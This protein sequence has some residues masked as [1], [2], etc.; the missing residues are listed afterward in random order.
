[1]LNIINGFYETDDLSDM[2]LLSNAFYQ[3]N[4]AGSWT[5]KVVDGVY[6]SWGTLTNWKIRFFGEGTCSN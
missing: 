1:M 3:E 5:I 2:V 6:L 4:S